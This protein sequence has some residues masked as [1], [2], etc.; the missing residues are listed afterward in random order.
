MELVNNKLIDAN[1][2]RLDLE[3]SKQFS[4]WIK[5]NIER[6]FLVENKDFYPSRDKTYIGR[7]PTKY[8][9][10][11]DAALAI[12]LVSGGKNAKAVRDKVIEL[13]NQH[14]T[15]LAFTA[16]QIEALMDLSKAMTLISIQKEVEKKH[17]DLYNQPQT[18]WNYRAAILGYSKESLIEGMRNVNKKHSSIRASLIKL[19]SNELIRTGVI[20][21]LLAMG[22]TT[23]YATNVGNLCKS[24]ASKMKLGDIIWDDTKEN[25]LKLNQSEI[26]E[27]KSNYVKINKL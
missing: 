22:K 27:I 15:G 8:Y 2:I 10:T 4:T 12:I 5:T 16:P 3:I 25:S 1:D 20:D 19:D 6:C 23:E 14:D 24:I 11:K 13:Y 17:F 7:T 9:L 21:L 18:W 26:S